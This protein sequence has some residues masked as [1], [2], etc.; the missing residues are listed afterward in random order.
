MFFCINYKMIYNYVNFITACD[1]KGGIGKDGNLPWSIPEEMRYFQSI[2]LNNVVVM[3]KTTYFS[4][5]NNYR[6]LRNR[7]N[8]V[9]TNDEELLKNDHGEKDLIFFNNDIYRSN[10]KDNTIFNQIDDYEEKFNY[11]HYHF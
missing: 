2:T 11:L 8:L 7:L 4:I 1:N 9:L 5:P 10:K 3:G 6:P